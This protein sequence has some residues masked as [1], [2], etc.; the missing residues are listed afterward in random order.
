MAYKYN[1]VY[2]SDDNF[3]MILLTSIVSL[4]DN[5][6]DAEEINIFILNDNISTENKNNIIK[7]INFYERNVF[8]IDVNSIRNNLEC[9]NLNI[10]R[11]SLSQY[12]RLFIDKLLPDNIDKVL[13]LDCDTL[14]VGSIDSLWNTN[15]IDTCLAAVNDAFS[16]YYREN[17]N[18]DPNI[19]LLNSGVL[20]INL[21]EWRKC[22]I[23]NKI[24]S[25]LK[26]EG[27]FVQQGDQ[28]VLNA[29]LQGNFKSLDLCFNAMSIVFELTFKEIKWYRNPIKFYSQE[30]VNKARKSP[31]IIHFTSGFYVIRPW[32]Q[33]NTYNDIRDKWYEYYPIK[34]NQPGRFSS[35]LM[36]KFK[37]IAIYLASPFQVYLRPYFFKIK[38]RKRSR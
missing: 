19:K 33:K 15:L 24:L 8:F 4:L 32:T 25:Y 34:I 37:K 12:Y 31:V 26:R 30:V 9:V 23:S 27:G 1:V 16:K 7:K 18:L 36:N 17:L 3:S 38:N 5:N 2:S 35:S 21:E 14:I 11:G 28:G 22:N 10:D 20:L 29:V 13:Y 6:K